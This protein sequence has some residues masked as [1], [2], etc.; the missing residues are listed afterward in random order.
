[1]KCPKCKGRKYIELDKIGLL[2]A[3]CD[4]CKGT[5]VVE[6]ISTDSFIT[7]DEEEIAVETYVGILFQR[8][9]GIPLGVAREGWRKEIL[10]RARQQG[11]DTESGLPFITIK[12]PCGVEIVYQLFDDIPE[13]DTPC[14][15]GNP[16]H[17]VVRYKELDD[18]AHK[19]IDA[20]E[21]NDNS[22]G[23]E[24]DNQPIGSTDTGKPTVTKKSKTRKKTRKKSR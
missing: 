15:C 4:E 13:V 23:V 2:T 3:E 1:M 21:A 9:S 20:Q 6:A 19:I 7:I 17:W 24:P 18:K 5:G 10:E 14:S 8:S 11:I 22:T 12:M 16:K